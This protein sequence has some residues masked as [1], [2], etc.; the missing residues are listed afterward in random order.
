MPMCDSV[1]FEDRE[2]RT[3][4]QLADLVDGQDKL[5]WQ[6][7]NPFKNWPEG[8]DWRDFDLCLCPIDLESTL[9]LAGFR[10]H[11]GADPMEYFAERL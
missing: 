5:V 3:P 9:K 8:K 6:S 2:Y 4:R 10:W 1:L 7:A 11:R